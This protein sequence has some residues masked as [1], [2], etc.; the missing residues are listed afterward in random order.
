MLNRIDRDSTNAGFDLELINV[1]KAAVSKTVIA[2]NGAGCAAHFLEVFTETGAE[3]A[4]ARGIFHRREAPIGK[5]KDSLEGKVEVR[6]A[7]A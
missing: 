4:L 3:S 1:V 6:S 5:V 2:S 7:R